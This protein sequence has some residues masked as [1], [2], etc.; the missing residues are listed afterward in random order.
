MKALTREQIDFIG[1]QWDGCMY[2]AVGETIDIGAAIRNSLSKLVANVA[3]TQMSQQHL[4]SIKEAA[5]TLESAAAYNRSKHRTVLA[6]TQQDRADRLRCSLAAAKESELERA[7]NPTQWTEEMS[8]A[9]HG[10]IPDVP[11]AF[12]ALRAAANTQTKKQ[13]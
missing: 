6:H 2:D 8:A 5:Q 11:K 13:G 9:W 1:E 10:A 4:D 3:P 7:L 12:A